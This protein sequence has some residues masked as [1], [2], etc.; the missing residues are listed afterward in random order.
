M[1][2]FLLILLAPLDG[3]QFLLT[4]AGKATATVAVYTGPGDIVSS[5][6]V[7]YGLRAYSTADRGNKLINV[8]NVADV[9][10]ADLSSDATTG[11][12]VV[13]TIGGSS[14]SVIACTVKI[15]YDRSGN[16]VDLTQAAPARRYI[17]T[18]NCIGTQWC[19]TTPTSDPFNGYQS[20]GS[21]TQAQ[22]NTVSFV[23]NRTADFTNY[24]VVFGN[25]V[26]GAYA[27]FGSTNEVVLS[28]PSAGIVTAADSAFHA[29]Q[30]V[31]NGAS[32]ILYVD[33]SSN[34]ISLGTQTYSSTFWVG[35]NTLNANFQGKLCEVG[36]WGSGFSGGNQS[37]MD[38]NQRTYWGF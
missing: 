26:N 30:G 12:L 29:V 1:L 32:S 3:Q 14:C 15:L 8:C 16:A 11:S 4:G 36:F 6:L 17:L 22:P 9:A 34:S 19:M 37:S 31:T 23:A 13:T 21:L 2:L 18:A 35:N 10:C 25:N 33:G 7:W 20:A 5:A 27:G 38:S 28:A 24:S